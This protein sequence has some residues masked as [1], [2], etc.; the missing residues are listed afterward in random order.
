MR[1]LFRYSSSMDQSVCWDLHNNANVNGIFFQSKAHFDSKCVTT[2]SFIKDSCCDP[3]FDKKCGCSE[4][5]TNED[6]E[7]Q[8]QVKKSNSDSEKSRH[9]A[10]IGIVTIAA[11]CFLMFFAYRRWKKNGIETTTIP[12]YG[13]DDP[14]LKMNVTMD[15]ESSSPTKPYTDSQPYRDST[16]ELD[17]ED[18]D[19]EEI[20]VREII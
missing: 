19:M 20:N 4:A 18:G 7:T 1:N 14:D 17:E 10:A 13:M 9:F 16:E 11:S 5:T 6:H 3:S 2:Q 12:D 15:M 8:Q